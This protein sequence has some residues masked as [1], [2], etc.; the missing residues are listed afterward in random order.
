MKKYIVSLAFLAAGLFAVA[1]NTAKDI[2]TK[3]QIVWFGVDF[4]KAK[5][6]G[7]FD[8]AG[9]AAPATASDLKY[10][11]VPGWNGVILNEPEKYNLKMTFRKTEVYKDLS[12][13][14]KSN[15]KIDPDKFLTYND[16]K[17]EIPNSVVEGIISSYGN[18][19]KTEGI[20]VVFIVEYFSKP[21]QK[22][23]F[24]VTFFDIATKKVLIAEHMTGMAGG[25]GIRN[26]WAR[27]FKELFEQIDAGAYRSWKNTYT[28]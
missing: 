25:I 1:Q 8:Q 28:Q 18:G 21:E 24:Y 14:E 5:M 17:F 6:V 3:D 11:Y 20:G 2:F 12:V 27:T 10:K 22:A 13:V 23:S 9:G 4:S 7:Q 26:Y 15:A 16:Y 19:D